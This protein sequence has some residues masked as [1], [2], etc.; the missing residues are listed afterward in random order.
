M[1]WRRRWKGLPPIPWRA[2]WEQ[3]EYAALARE[4]E[5]RWARREDEL[6]LS[7]AAA[8]EKRP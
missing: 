5:A 4:V 8:C 2:P 6:L 7:L 1:H 3:A